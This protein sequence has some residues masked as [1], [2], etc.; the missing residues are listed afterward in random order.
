MQ[1]KL[2]IITH[3]QKTKQSIGTEIKMLN[4]CS[5]LLSSSIFDVKGSLKEITEEHGQFI[6]IYI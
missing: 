6:Y 5:L 3:N 1:K 2:K 4:V